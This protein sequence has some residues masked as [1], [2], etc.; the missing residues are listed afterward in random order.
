MRSV[1]F[2]LFII[3]VVVFISWSTSS[4]KN[5]WQTMLLIFSPS[6][7]TAESISDSLKKEFSSNKSFKD[8]F[9]KDKEYKDK[10]MREWNE[11]FRGRTKKLRNNILKSLA[12]VVIILC[13]SFLAAYVFNKYFNISERLIYI[14]QVLAASLILWALLSKLG[15]SIQ[16]I[17]GTTLQEQINE[18]WFRILNSIGAF[19]LFFTYFYNL[20][21][22]KI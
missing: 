12:I 10:T 1:S 11:R 20:F 2:V 17:N 15:W 3:F 16:T 7:F 6:K 13:F 9:E 4:I 22:R 8:G 5:F 14:L 21:R 19:L 18:Y